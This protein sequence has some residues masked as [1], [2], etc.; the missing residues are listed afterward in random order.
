MCMEK[1]ALDE[2]IS[3]CIKSTQNNTCLRKYISLYRKTHDNPHHIA[4][5]DVLNEDVIKEKWNKRL[6]ELLLLAEK[7]VST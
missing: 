4:Q 3:T 6:T 2:H 7:H 5:S 1:D